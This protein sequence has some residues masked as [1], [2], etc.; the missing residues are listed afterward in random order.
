M[1]G[2][3]E[4]WICEGDDNVGIEYNDDMLQNNLMV[5]RVRWLLEKDQFKIKIKIKSVKD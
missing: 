2:G 1:G 3:E 5:R 4:L